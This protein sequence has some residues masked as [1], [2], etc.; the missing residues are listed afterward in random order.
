MRLPLVGFHIRIDIFVSI[1][2]LK[3][4]YIFQFGMYH[5]SGMGVWQRFCAVML[6]GNWGEGEE[7]NSQVR[8]SYQ[9]QAETSLF[10]KQQQ[11][12]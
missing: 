10:V 1:K 9:S 3:T 12:T 4:G 7:I 11:S 8:P 2:K 6:Y 5:P